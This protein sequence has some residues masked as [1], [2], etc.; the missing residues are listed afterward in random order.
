MRGHPERGAGEGT[1]PGMIRRWRL[2]LLFAFLSSLFSLAVAT[3][4][5]FTGFELKAYDLL[6][7]TFNPGQSTGSVIIVKVDQ[8]SLDS[9]NSEG[10]PWPWPRQ[11][12]A[13]IIEYLSEAEAVFIDVLFLEPSSYGN[14]D[15]VIL[16][17]AIKDSANVYL[18]LAL[19]DK[20]EGLDDEER[21]FLEKHAVGQVVP[22]GSA[23]R[24]AVLP[25]PLLR[26]AVTGTG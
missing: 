17:A 25:L 11:V 14:E 16:A 6:S 10:I 12:Y 19:T 2:I 1:A 26:P 3:S 21:A 9:L 18:P 23:F 24:S 4:G 13:A 15:D 22:Q 20:R 7:R 8:A 5:L